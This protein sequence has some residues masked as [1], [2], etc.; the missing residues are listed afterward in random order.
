MVS[1]QPIIIYSFGYRKYCCGLCAANHSR[2]VEKK[3]ENEYQETKRI[4]KQTQEDKL[5]NYIQELKDRVH[6][7]DWEGDQN[8]W[9]GGPRVRLTKDNNNM[10][11]DNSMTYIDGQ[12]YSSK[13]QTIIENEDQ[14]LNDVFWL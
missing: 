8:T 11:T 7:F 12:E 14:S 2:K 3:I 6:E 13:T 9:A 4:E 1:Q 10:L 5:N